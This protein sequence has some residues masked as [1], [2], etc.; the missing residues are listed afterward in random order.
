MKW[1]EY[2][3][4]NL[5]EK[6]KEKQ[7]AVLPVGTI[8]PHG[9]HLP[10]NTDAYIAEKLAEKTASKLDFIVGP[11][12]IGSSAIKGFPG[13][14]SYEK[15]SKTIFKKTC[16][17]MLKHV[18]K[19]YI[20]NG[21][22]GNSEAVMYVV[23]MLPKVIALPVWWKMNKL[24]ELDESRKEFIEN[25]GEAED[26][27]GT[28]AGEIETSLMLALNEGLVDK[29]RIKD[30]YGP[31]SRK[32]LNQKLNIEKIPLPKVIPNAVVGDARKA[33][34]EKGKKMLDFIVREY[35]KFIQDLY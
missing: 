8:E 29:N 10:L 18:K 1:S 11:T 30:A 6:L 14:I 22:G 13:I 21:C 27:C 12:L 23:K 24:L 15:N 31:Q 3:F 32:Y 7:Y 2:S 16:E 17:Q 33:S 20:V 34:K 25:G 26:W 19:V 9:P 35:V 4:K 5:E 28:H